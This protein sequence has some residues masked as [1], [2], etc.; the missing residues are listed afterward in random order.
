MIY[1]SMLIAWIFNSLEKDLQACMAYVE[2]AKALWHDMRERFSQGNETR[3]YEIKAEIC[4]LKQEGK[5]IP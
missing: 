3:I 4:L 5:T 2:D 1:N